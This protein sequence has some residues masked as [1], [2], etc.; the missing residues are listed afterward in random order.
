MLL[1]KRQDAANNPYHSREKIRH[2]EHSL[3][4]DLVLDPRS[5]ILSKTGTVS[6][7]RQW[8]LFLYQEVGCPKSSLRDQAMDLPRLTSPSFFHQQ[9][10][11]PHPWEP[12]F[13]ADRVHK[14][15]VCRNKGYE[16]RSSRGQNSLLHRIC[17]ILQCEKLNPQKFSFLNRTK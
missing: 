9:S 14:R 6:E 1:L 4:A 8:P 11:P 5:A 15:S 3:F 16:T 2:R 17:D 12:L 10:F 7:D 13:K